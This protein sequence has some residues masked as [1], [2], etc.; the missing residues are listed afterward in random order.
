MDQSKIRNFVITAHI[1][2]GKSTLS[3]RFLETTGTVSRREMKDQIL[4]NMDL[5]RERGITIKLAP[6]RMS[7]KGYEL[8]LIDTPGHVDFTYEV[9]R[10][11]A[12]VEGA[13]LLVDAT[14]GIQAQTIANL[15]LALEQDLKIIPAV[16]KID[17]PAAQPEAAR[18]ELVKLLGCLPEEVLF[19]SGKSGAGVSE[20]LDAVVERVPPPRGKPS[21]PLRAVIFD[22]FYDD[23]RGV[24]AYIRVVDGSL[25]AGD[26]VR[27]MA[28][29][30]DGEALEVGV[31]APRMK[32]T[33]ALQT[34]ET[35][36]LVTGLKD[37]SGCRVGDTVTLAEAQ[38]EPLPG[39]REVKP[40]VFAGIFAKE[41][42]GYERLREAM[43][44]LKLSDSSLSFEPER[45]TALGFGFRV[46]LLGLLHLEIVQERLRREY[47]LD[48]IVTAPSVAYRVLRTDGKE[49]IA[50]SPQDLPDATHLESVSEPW[51]KLSVICR[52]EDIGGV[53]SLVA[54]K[55]GAYKN[56][57]YLGE[58]QKRVA[59]S[60]ELPLAAIVV[61]FY[62]K[63][64][65]VSSGYA[66][67]SYEFS[68]Y[69]PADVVRMNIL[70]AE[71]PVEALASLVYRDE[72]QRAGRRVVEALK[73]SIPRQMFEVKIQAAIGGSASSPGTGKIIAAERIPAMR[74]DMMAK[75]SGGDVTRK[76]KLLEKQKKGKKAM[77]AAGHVDLPP[78]TYLAVL[79]R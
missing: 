12:S 14:Q 67:M 40:M 48:L 75:M 22:S 28:T 2:H 57:E 5:E 74:K 66:S 41:G 78:E 19:V 79:K 4:D 37:I 63:L 62:D 29:K 69:R 26:R 18:D 9:S 24:V 44:K 11:L 45:S 77:K 6:A 55:R 35:G 64:K 13:I 1:D 39:Y 8:N 33:G 51:V 7:W 58:G 70:V 42:S 27:F 30:T 10:S 16:N 52:E 59:I 38:V 60:A 73:E 50:K 3:D 23:Y 46:G 21:E 34:G 76:M 32:S 72:A 20:L 15:Y 36:Y 56:T 43:L 53:L 25:K 47:G 65:S 68:D 17:L 61:D 54:E 71:E 31:L 49:I